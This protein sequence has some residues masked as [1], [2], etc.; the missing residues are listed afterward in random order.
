MQAKRKT[1]SEEEKERRRAYF[2][3]YRKVWRAENKER[4][5]AMSRKTQ[6]KQYEMDPVKHRQRSAAARYGI[7]VP[8]YLALIESRSGVCD[9]CGLVSA[10]TLHIDHCHATGKIRGVL[11]H[12]CNTALGNVKDDPRRLRSLIDYLA[13]AA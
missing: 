9:A 7:T 10:K 5:R 12:N 1:M 3:A 8:E 4:D 6:A 13:K 11:C 2:T